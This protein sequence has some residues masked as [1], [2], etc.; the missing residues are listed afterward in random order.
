MPRKSEEKMGTF[1]CSY[2]IAGRLV[3]STTM[4]RTSSSTYRGTLEKG[5]KT[6]ERSKEG[7]GKS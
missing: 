5:R 2:M 1:G 4:F 3:P 6:D 7:K